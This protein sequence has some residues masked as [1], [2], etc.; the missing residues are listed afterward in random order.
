MKISNQQYAYISIGIVILLG[1]WWLTSTAPKSNP[2]PPPTEEIQNALPSTPQTITGWLK[3]SDNPQRGNLMLETGKEKIYL[4]TGRNY[5]HLLN[6]Q[7]NIQIK[8]TLENFSL[9]DIT[10]K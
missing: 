4:F 10:T 6:T 3:A 8:G 9:I 1:G 2:N 5:N 7:V